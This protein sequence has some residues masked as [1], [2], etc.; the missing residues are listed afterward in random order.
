MLGWERHVYRRR[1]LCGE[2]KKSIVMCELRPREFSFHS[3]WDVAEAKIIDDFE[4]QGGIGACNHAALEEA[5]DGVARVIEYKADR[6][7]YYGARLS[8]LANDF[9]DVCTAFKNMGR[10]HAEHVK[11][12]FA[13]IDEF[14]ISKLSLK[15]MGSESSLNPSLP[16]SKTPASECL[17]IGALGA[18]R[19]TSQMD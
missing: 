9:I 7:Q 18:N 6:G 1:L 16:G 15:F 17:S 8:L 4:Y 12:I 5:M 14:L 11:G 3:Y 10:E 19:I 2:I 13:C